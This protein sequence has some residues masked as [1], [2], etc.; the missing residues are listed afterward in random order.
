MVFFNILII[1]SVIGIGVVFWLLKNDPEENQDESAPESVP[2]IAQ[3][4]AQS[5]EKSSLKSKFTALFGKKQ[6]GSDGSEPKLKLSLGLLGEAFNKVKLN[7]SKP[8]EAASQK[9][10]TPDLKEYFGPEKKEADGDIASNQ[11][12]PL[13]TAGITT[14]PPEVSHE[15]K[16]LSTKEE[17]DIGKEIELSAELSELKKKYDKLEA[18]FS[19]KNT[20]YEKAKE[21]LDNELGNR[22]EFNKVKDLLE[23][24]LKE[25]KD[26]TRNTQGEL[27]NARTENENQKKRVAQLEEKTGKLEKGLLEKEDKIDDLAKRIQTSASP[28]T[29]A[30]PPETE[31]KKEGGADGETSKIDQAPVGPPPESQ[32]QADPP[33]E[34]DQ[35]KEAPIREKPVQNI[36]KSP[37]PEKS[38][39]APSAEEP[40]QNGGFKLN[41]SIDQ[42]SPPIQPDREEFLELKPDVLASEPQET[43]PKEK[44]E[45]PSQ[46]PSE[47][48]SGDQKSS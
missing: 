36:E 46:P 44:P 40:A 27:N 20:E 1:L 23:K 22:K 28:A 33:V 24:E 26:R 15:K 14:T 29:A 30:T 12:I 31:E 41:I 4:P 48:A 35:T 11:Q 37:E 9:T 45:G 34:N 17:E 43:E 19:E 39:P 2:E 18:L 42:D 8:D 5:P 47:D 32:P 38:E 13:G 25:S 10:Q 16:T 3:A 7:K 6:A 21:S